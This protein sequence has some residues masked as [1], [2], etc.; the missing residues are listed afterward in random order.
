MSDAEAAL[1]NAGARLYY[2]VSPQIGRDCAKCNVVALVTVK[3]ERGTECLA[4]VGDD[5]CPTTDT[6]GSMATDELFE[7]V[8]TEDKLIELRP[9]DADQA[10]EII[11]MLISASK[12]NYTNRSFYDQIEYRLA[13]ALEEIN[14]R[15]TARASTPVRS[16]FVPDTFSPRST[17]HRSESQETAFETPRS[18]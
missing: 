7:W 16:C 2:R 11:S 1:R 4:Y 14:T 12:K 5:L 13:R 8:A 15:S 6:A 17:V 9:R 10:A 3:N 18:A